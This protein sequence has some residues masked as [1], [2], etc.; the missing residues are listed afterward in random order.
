MVGIILNWVVVVVV[1]AIVGVVVEDG[2]EVVTPNV[3]E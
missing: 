1:E 2:I 3:P